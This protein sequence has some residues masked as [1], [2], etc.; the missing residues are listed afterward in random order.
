MENLCLSLHLEDPM[1]EDGDEP[2]LDD[3]LPAQNFEGQNPN[4][5]R[6][7]VEKW[8]QIMNML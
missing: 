7:G 5:T 1:E 3:F 6:Q 2:E 8:Q 4:W